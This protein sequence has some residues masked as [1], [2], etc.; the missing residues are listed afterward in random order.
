MQP[1]RITFEFAKRAFIQTGM[2]PI[3]LDCFNNRGGADALGAICMS[4]GSD[5]RYAEFSAFTDLLWGSDYTSGFIYGYDSNTVND[6]GNIAEF[7]LG[8]QD[9]RSVWEALVREGMVI[10]DGENTN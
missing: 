4:L 8:V 9:G 6:Q 7:N 5:L 2:H 10:G 1:E 3:R